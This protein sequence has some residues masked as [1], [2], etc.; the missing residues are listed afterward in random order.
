MVNLGFLLQIEQRKQHL[1]ALKKPKRPTEN[2]RD[3]QKK[4]WEQSKKN[5]L[6]YD[7]FLSLLFFFLSVS[8]RYSFTMP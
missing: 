1:D 5:A 2:Q 8:T 6:L 3:Q 4:Q 7:M